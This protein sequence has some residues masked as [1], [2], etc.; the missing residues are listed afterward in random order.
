LEKVL[1]F[2]GLEFGEI[3]KGGWGTW[4]EMGVKLEKG[5]KG[6]KKFSLRKALDERVFNILLNLFQFS[7]LEN[8]YF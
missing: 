4:L 5:G 2:W 3:F 8:F 7:S 6:R 1:N